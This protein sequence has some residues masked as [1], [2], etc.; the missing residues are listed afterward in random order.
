MASLCSIHVRTLFN[1]IAIQRAFLYAEPDS[2]IWTEHKV[3]QWMNPFKENVGRRAPSFLSARLWV[4]P[5]AP[6]SFPA[7]RAQAAPASANAGKPGL[8]S[9]GKPWG[10]KRLEF[11]WG[12]LHSS[13]FLGK[14]TCEQILSLDPCLRYTTVYA[15]PCICSPSPAAPAGLH[16]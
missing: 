10:R 12:E 5:M 11:H 3:W 2:P 16:T 9:L 14:C 4:Q 13:H 6:L 1:S 7:P 8:T 15:Q